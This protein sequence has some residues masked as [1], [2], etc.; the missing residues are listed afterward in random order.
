MDFMGIKWNGEKKTKQSE[1]VT[2]YMILFIKR[3]WNN[4]IKDW[5]DR[6]VTGSKG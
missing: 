3:S 6:L 5:E 2:Y 1:K 4:K